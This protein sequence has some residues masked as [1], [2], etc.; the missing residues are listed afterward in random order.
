MRLLVTRDDT[1]QVWVAYTDFAW[2][3]SRHNITNRAAQFK[4]ASEV[5]SSITASVA[6]PKP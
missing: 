3:A 6:A 4:M 2:I 5:I 1:G